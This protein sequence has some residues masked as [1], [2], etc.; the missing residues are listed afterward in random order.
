MG[1][2]NQYVGYAP[3]LVTHMRNGKNSLKVGNGEKLKI[4]ASGSTKLKTLNVHD[5][6]YVP[7][8]SKNLL[9]VSKL[10]TDN[11][12]RVEFDVDR[13]SVKDKLTGKAFLRGRET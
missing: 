7:K 1:C 12:I 5:V 6:L 2:P 8:I 10:T 11:N 4:V 9:S 13:C 3:K